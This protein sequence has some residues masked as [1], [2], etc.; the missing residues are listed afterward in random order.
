VSDLLALYD[1]YE[2]FSATSPDVRREELPHLVRHV[3]LVGRSGTVIFSRLSAD[4]ADAAIEQECGYF[5]SL[6]QDLEWKAYAHDQPAD[7]VQ[8]LAAHGF[9]QDE[10]EAILVLDVH[11]PP[12]ALLTP[13]P[14]VKRLHQVDELREVSVIKQQLGDNRPFERLA[15]ELE[16]APDYLSVYVVYAGDLPAGCG[17]IRFPESSPF[18]SLWGGATLPELRNQGF[19]TALLAARVQEARARGWRY[20]TIDAGHMSRPIVEKRGFRLLTYA[21]A[22]NWHG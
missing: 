3:D 9:D 12:A 18:A 11:D 17:W 8:R 13:T 20:V 4:N 16:H 21:T 10:T 6:G 22:C 1:R 15:Y 2:R 14:H 19:Y 7:L 5:H